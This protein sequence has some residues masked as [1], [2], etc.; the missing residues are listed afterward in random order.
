[1]DDDN[2][3]MDTWMTWTEPGKSSKTRSWCL[4]GWISCRK[5][6]VLIREIIVQTDAQGI[7]GRGR[8]MV[9]ALWPAK[10]MTD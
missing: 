4:S 9:I 1:M 7:E 2:L 5:T 10:P 3:L 8:V 6:I